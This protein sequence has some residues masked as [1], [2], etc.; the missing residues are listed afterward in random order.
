VATAA[1]HAQHRGRIVSPLSAVQRSGG[2]DC[3]PAKSIWDCLPSQPDSALGPQTGGRPVAACRPR[4]FTAR[5]RGGA[6][7]AT[8][9]VSPRAGETAGNHR[10][11]PLA[12]GPRRTEWRCHPAHRPAAIATPGRRDAA[13]DPCVSGS[14]FCA[15]QPPRRT[16]RSYPCSERPD[17][18]S[19]IGD[20]HASVDNGALARLHRE[21]CPLP[22]LQCTQDVLT[23][24]SRRAPDVLA[25]ARSYSAAA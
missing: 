6:A 18:T 1:L 15:R 12:P 14:I 24:Y 2:G 4:P 7:R 11:R 3:V 22:R 5:R 16:Y 10:P 19:S 25:A 20:G 21:T 9:V 13:H 23:M 17:S 8:P